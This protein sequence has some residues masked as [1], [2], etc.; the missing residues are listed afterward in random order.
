MIVRVDHIPRAVELP[1]EPPVPTPMLRN[2]M[3]N[4]DHP[5]RGAAGQPPVNEQPDAVRRGQV[6]RTR[7]ACSGR[8]LRAVPVGRMPRMTIEARYSRKRVLEEPRDLLT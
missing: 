5:P 1:G 3:R 6:E 4:M 8:R 2:A 7:F